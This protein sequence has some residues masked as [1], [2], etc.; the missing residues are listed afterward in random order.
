MDVRLRP[1][2]SGSGQAL[3]GA[4]LVL[5]SALF[6]YGG[7]HDPASVGG[8]VFIVLGVIGV[9]GFGAVLTVTLGHLLG[10][11]PLLILDDTGVLIPAK[12]PLSR[13]R[14]RFLPWDEIAAACAWSLGVPGGKGLQHQLAFLPRP[15][16]AE[17]A[18]T[19]GSEI[20]QVKTAGLDGVPVLRW[21]VPML[22]GWTTRHDEVLA[23]VRRRLPYDDRRVGL[24]KKRIIV[25][26]RP[27]TS[28]DHPTRGSGAR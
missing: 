6:V 18:H 1:S 22:P 7:S 11:R 9:L 24:P 21:S 13:N 2:L 28:G 20:L 27:R 15:G 12:W 8:L 26:K 17:A 5:C 19:S 4:T 14:D 23:E 10:R 16:T 25:R 3:G